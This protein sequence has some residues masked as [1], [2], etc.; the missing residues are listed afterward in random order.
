MQRLLHAE[1]PRAI[2]QSGRNPRSAYMAPFPY[3]QRSFRLFPVSFI[4]AEA[5][6]I[7]H[8]PSAPSHIFGMLYRALVIALSLQ[9]AGAW[10]PAVRP[11][12]ASLA[13][14]QVFMVDQ[15]RWSNAKKGDKAIVGDA[16]EG[17]KWARAAWAFAQDEIEAGQCYRI[18][19]NADVPEDG[20]DYYFCATPSPDA[21]MTCE[22]M[23]E[24]MGELEDGTA[25]YICYSITSRHCPSSPPNRPRAAPSALVLAPV[26][27]PPPA[28]AL[29][30]PGLRTL[31]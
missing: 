9:V 14:A 30:P 21:K 1:S 7:P 10:T 23:P 28:V 15:M 25:V 8:H 20:K 27:P 19:E 24:W 18:D 16:P 17:I 13:R 26:P 4:G 6:V 22:E 3:L 29:A 5:P 11:P 31:R 12:V 2:T